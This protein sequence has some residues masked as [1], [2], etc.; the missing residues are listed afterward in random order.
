MLP[1]DLAK[2]HTGRDLHTHEPH[3]GVFIQRRANGLVRI[4]FD[5]WRLD[6]NLRPAV[7][8]RLE[9]LWN[10]E[11]MGLS[12]S[13][14]RSVARRVHISKSFARFEVRPE[15]VEAWK[16]ELA[17]ILENPDS[18]EPISPRYQREQP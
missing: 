13:M 5:L 3:L 6:V 14:R 10:R 9:N 17:A 12:T 15:T 7:L 8:E 16:A 1:E 18:F 4:G 2:I 11:A